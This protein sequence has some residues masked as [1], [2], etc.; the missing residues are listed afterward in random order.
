MEARLAQA[1][2]F[3]PMEKHPAPLLGEDSAYEDAG[4]LLRVFRKK[5]EAV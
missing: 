1:S 4:P 5:A 2:P 3:W